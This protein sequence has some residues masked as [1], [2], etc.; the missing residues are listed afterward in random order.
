MKLITGFNIN[1]D[2]FPAQSTTRDYSVQG[3]SGAVFSLKV[4]RSSDGY[5]YDFV[6]DSFTTTET[7][8]NRLANQEIQ[9]AFSSSL[10]FPAAAGATYTIYLFAEP[11]F[12][13]EISDTLSI[14]PVLY[15]TTLTQIADSTVTLVSPPGAAKVAA[16]SI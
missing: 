6:S 4:Q 1:T 2:D 8:R 12:D 5:W 9:G 13:T 10:S 16:P 3:D 7:S 14:S 11:H 15:T